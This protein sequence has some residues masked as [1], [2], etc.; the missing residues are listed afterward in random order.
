MRGGL[1][2]LW[3][4]ALTILLATAVASAS[5]Q[6]RFERKLNVGGGAD[7]QVFTRSGDVTIRSGPAGTV[8]IIGHIHVGNRW[9]GGDKNAEVE[10][11]ERN[12]PIQQSGNN[13]RIDYVN[14]QNIS[15]DYE[16]TASSDTKVRTKS[17]SGDL[18]I[19]GMQAG[20]DV[21]TG[22]GDVRLED[23]A[24]DLRIQTGSGN[25]QARGAA[26]PLEARA[27][28]GD[29]K[30]EE[31]SKGDVRLETGSGDIEARG[32]DGGLRAS[33]GSGN[34]HVDGTPASSWSV[35]T[36]SGDAELRLPQEAAFD[37][38]LSSSSGSVSV[39]HPVTTTIQGRIEESRK[40]I[41]GKVRGGGPEIS[42]HTGSGDVRVD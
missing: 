41:R 19:E 3:A 18:T 1:T 4:V 13:I 24:G 38:D 32:I 20:I 16:I 27:G 23:L 39:N 21:E 12:P 5:E 22:S 9:F 17:G 26:G 6:G 11:I 35:R 33:T 28:S 29:I 2:K 8:G 31:R 14:R 30:I 34:V 7:L 10:D 42:V 15:I 25:V 40:S 36:G 37:L